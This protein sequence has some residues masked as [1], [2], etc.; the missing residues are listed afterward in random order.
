MEKKLPEGWKEYKI[1]DIGDVVT[2]STPPKKDPENYGGVLPWIKPP[3]L[4]IDKFVS[5]SEETISETGRKKVRL[6]PKGSVLVSCIGNIG[7][8][9]IADT[10][11]CTNQQIN[12]IIPDENIVVSD[13]LYYTIKKIRPYLE[14]I[15]SSAVVPL[16]NKTDFSN[17]NIKLPPLETQKKIVSILEKAEETR[18]L[19]AQ[20]DELTQKLLQSVFLEMFGDPVKNSREWKLHKLGEIGNW[21]SGGTPSRSKP[22]YFHGEIPWF[23]AGELN[24][25]YVYGSKEKITKEALNSSSAKLFPAGTMLIGMYDTAA[26]KMG[27]LKNPASSNQ[28]CA[29]FSPKVEVINT[30]F[31]LYLFKEMKDSFLSQ[32]RGIRQK[33]LSQSIIKKFEVPVPP[34]ELQKQFADMVQKIDQIKESQKQSSLETN[35]LFDALMQKAF[36]GKL[37]S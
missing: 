30:L 24:D 17:I 21:T 34:I 32:R 35:N 26:F 37:V 12:S 19:R 23:T 31:A 13:F 7:K 28:A 3:D 25:S 4:D 8:V 1:K 2:G 16:L 15:A 9:A 14:N 10:E 22:E 20:A 33:N 36:T 27:I 5:T 11:L 29:A 6:L 18:K